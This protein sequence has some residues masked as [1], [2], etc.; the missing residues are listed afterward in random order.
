MVEAG[1]IRKLSEDEKKLG[2]V[3]E[4]G[5]PEVKKVFLKKLHD[6]EQEYA[7]VHKPFCRTCAIHD[8]DDLLE[9]KKK[10]L[11]RRYNYVRPDSKE[12]LAVNIKDLDRYGDA[13]RFEQG[14]SQEVVEHKLIDG[15]R[16]PY[17]TGVWENFVCKVN[18]DKYSVFVPVE[19]VNREALQV[20]APLLKPRR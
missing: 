9:A 7:K 15:V 4:V 14:E 18:G 2:G 6:K 12:L 17:V 1:V 3:I 8:F 5:A 19:P 16:Q 20:K 11:M 10:E 13:A